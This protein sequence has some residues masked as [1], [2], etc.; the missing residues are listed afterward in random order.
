MAG[1]EALPIDGP[2]WQ[3]MRLSR[4]RNWGQPELSQVHRE[5]FGRRRRHGGWNGLLIGDM[6]QPRGGPMITGHASHQIGLDVDI[7]LEPMPDHVMSRAEREKKGAQSVLVRGKRLTLDPR[8]WSDADTL[9]LEARRVL[10]G[11]GA[12]L[13]QRR[14]QEAAVRDRRHRPRLAEEDPPVVRPRRPHPCAPRLPA[15]RVRLRRPGGPA[16]RRRLRQ[17]ARLVVPAAAAAA[18]AS[19]V[20]PKPPP[21]EKTLA[22]LPAACAA[23]ADRGA[24]RRGADGRHSAAG[25]AAGNGGQLTSDS[26]VSVSAAAR[27]RTKALGDSP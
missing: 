7:W 6:S 25:A 21:P 9:L 5:A 27:P 18:Q 20:K 23:G 11:G 4:N 8:K 26:A 12:H 13:R 16:A 15:G 2:H 3:V 24:R 14:D 10:P 22:D 19:A 17:G 1:G